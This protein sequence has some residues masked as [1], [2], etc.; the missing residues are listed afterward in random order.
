M[1]FYS[2]FGQEFEVS[3]LGIFTS[4]AH[5]YGHAIFQEYIKTAYKGKYSDIIKKLEVLS[6]RSLAVNQGGADTTLK[7]D[8]ETMYSS[9]EFL[10][11]LYY[12]EM[13]DSEFNSLRLRGFAEA[14]DSRYYN[15]MAEEESSNSSTCKN[16]HEGHY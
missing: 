9:D 2:K 7:T 6:L 8:L 1:K 4:A 11:S 10:N 3:P 13:T 5:E 15:L 12:E 16:H 14:P